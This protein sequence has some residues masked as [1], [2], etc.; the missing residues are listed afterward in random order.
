MPMHYKDLDTQDAWVVN[1]IFEK[2]KT[3]EYTWI[4]N[5]YWKLDE[6]SCVLVK[7]NRVWFTTYAAYRFKKIWNIIETERNTGYAHRAPKK[8]E[9]NN[10]ISEQAGSFQMRLCR[11]VL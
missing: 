1:T 10:M 11:I 9:T 2:Q 4:R 6:Y 7:R 8:R 3:G 5:I